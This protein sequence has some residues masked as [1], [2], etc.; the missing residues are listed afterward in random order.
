[1]SK[2]NT[3]DSYMHTQKSKY[4]TLNKRFYTWNLPYTTMQI[5]SH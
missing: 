1:M 2:Y 5:D 4:V 3:A